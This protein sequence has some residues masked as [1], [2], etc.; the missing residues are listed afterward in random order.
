M[1]GYTPGA[2]SFGD[3]DTWG[4]PGIAIGTSSVGSVFAL[5]ARSALALG[6]S[7]S[8]DEGVEVTDTRTVRGTSA[9]CTP[10]GPSGTAWIVGAA[11]AGG[12]P[13]VITVGTKAACAGGILPGT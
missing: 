5:D 1:S 3:S 7:A 2:C 6:V 9:A 13:V 12:T 11:F 10:G 4:A 8:T